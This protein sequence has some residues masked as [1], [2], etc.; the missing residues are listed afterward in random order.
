MSF[1]NPIELLQLNYYDL[2][3]LSQ[4]AIN[5]A[6]ASLRDKLQHETVK[7]N[8]VSIDENS[9]QLAVDQLKKSDDLHFYYHLAKYPGLTAFL[10]GNDQAEIEVDALR[11]H[12]DQLAGRA[13]AM[14]ESR[15]LTL[16][17]SAFQDADFKAL[18]RFHQQIGKGNKAFQEEVYHSSLPLLEERRDTVQGVLNAMEAGEN[19]SSQ[20][21]GLQLFRTH[22][23]VDVLNAL[24]TP[25][26]EIKNG[27]R[28]Q[29]GR[30]VHALSDSDPALALAIARYAHRIKGN[31]VYTKKLAESIAYLQ[32]KNSNQS[33]P[34]GNKTTVA[35]I[36]AIALLLFGGGIWYTISLR[37]KL[38]ATIDER[39]ID[40]YERIKEKEQYET[41]P[42]AAIGQ[43]FTHLPW[44]E[45]GD[46]APGDGVV[47]NG[48]SPMMAC[49]P[50]VSTKGLQK[51]VTIVGDPSY[52][53]LVFFF[54]G[55]KY[56]QQA[57][58]PAGEKYLIEHNLSGKNLSTMIIFGQDWKP[59]KP[60]PCGSNG[61]FSKN[62]FY[63]GFASYATDPP[64]LDLS[65]QD[66]LRLK[67]G[68]LMPSRQ[69]KEYEFFELLEEYR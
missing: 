25:F 29:L 18:T 41:S 37:N 4:D 10:Y 44:Y 46:D 32:R 58:I 56:F 48:S 12:A 38:E 67:K 34:K 20:L 16:V 36:V 8:D 49:F 2:D 31:E 62:V 47:K 7:I 57:Y 55:K 24:P 27:I 35:I 40:N 66:V 9:I 17:T 28:K 43:E 52:D 1:I 30:M 26:D 21:K 61:F 3:K 39:Y 65:V 15:A 13:S 68:R 5:S 54:N 33:Q 63:A 59:E 51:V 60:S 19:I 42:G 50:T 6:A 22:I 14:V 69:K 11:L 45:R 53:A 23:P 64:Y